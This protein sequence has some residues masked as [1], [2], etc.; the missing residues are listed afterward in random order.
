MIFVSN[1]KDDVAADPTKV[2]IELIYHHS[3]SINKF[4]GCGPEKKETDVK[5]P[6]RC[7]TAHRRPDGSLA[8]GGATGSEGGRAEGEVDESHGNGGTQ[9]KRLDE[10]VGGRVATPFLRFA[11]KRH[12]KQLL[13]ELRPFAFRF[14]IDI[15]KI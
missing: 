14:V 3:D 10:A 4:G 15:H 5:R 1:L 2:T 8:V 9:K 6:Q 11:N 12:R 7:Q 13:I